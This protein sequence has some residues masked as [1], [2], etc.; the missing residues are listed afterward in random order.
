MELPNIYWNQ[1][2]THD[3]ER[4]TSQIEWVGDLIYLHCKVHRNTPGAIRAVKR[5]LGRLLERFYNE[6]IDEVYCYLEKGEFAKMLGG[7][8]LTSFD[9]EERHYEVYSYATSSRAGGGG[10]CSRR[11]HIL[12]STTEQGSEEGS[13]SPGR[14][15]GH[16]SSPAEESGDGGPKGANTSAEDSSSPDTTSSKHPRSL[17]EFW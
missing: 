15:C 13:G 10:N 16:S 9:I 8:L 17:S 5:E 14:S 11:E 2:I 3:D 12:S 7:T 4:F 1:E 6:G